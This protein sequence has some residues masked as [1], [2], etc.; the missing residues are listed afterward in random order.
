MLALASAA[1][2]HK[3]TIVTTRTVTAFVPASCAV[4]GGGY[5]TYVALGDFEP[6][7]VQPGPF[8]KDVGTVLPQI[9]TQARELVVTASENDRQWAGAAPVPSAGD[10]NVLLM[11]QAQSCRLTGPAGARTESTFAPIGSRLAMLA[12]GTFNPT[13]ATYVVNLDTGAVSAAN[14]DLHTPRAEGASVTAFGDGGLV[15]GGL[16]SSGDPTDEA[17]VYSPSAGGF[18]T[19]FHL[20]EP[21]SLHAAV[22]LADGRTLLVGG[23]GVV[24]GPPWISFMEIVDPATNAGHEENVAQLDPVVTSPVAVRLASGEILVAGQTMAGAANFTALQWFTPDA[25][26]SSKR[27]QLIGPGV[28]TL[29]PLAAGGALAVVD[30]DPKI[31]TWV[32]DAS[33]VVEPATPTGAPL[34]SPRL[35]AGGGGAPVLWTGRTWLRWQP[36]AA[37]FE[38]LSTLDATPPAVSVA[39]CSPEPGLAMWLDVGAQQIA[40]MRFDTRNAF[41]AL[42]KGGAVDL[43]TDTAPDRIATSGAIALDEGTGLLTLSAPGASVFVTDRTYADVSITMTLPTSQ[44]PLVVLRDE[45]GAELAVGSSDACPGLLAAKS[46]TSL[47][48]ERRGTTVTWSVNG[49]AAT[50]CT[51]ALADGARV[52]VGL[53]AGSTQAVAR[54]LFV[55]RAGEP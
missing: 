10:V 8:L 42:A 34:A 32:I 49:G 26:L 37:R 23:T 22:V 5:A 13:P 3:D 35:F 9:D 48:V 7:Q 51:T 24:G 31:D 55:K 16:H 30:A 28:V 1:A 20:S 52:S 46:V 38:L 12:G 40:G 21:R 44:P 11:P 39:A 2:C 6:G 45:L 53:R 54:D 41:S 29:A 17:E 50:P 18:T 4:D 14:P 25:R 27:T 15:A 36:Y 43:A 19:L 47:D 33:G